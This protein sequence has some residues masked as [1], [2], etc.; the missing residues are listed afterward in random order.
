MAMLM[1]DQW[2]EGHV[3]SLIV[4]MRKCKDM[5]GK[6]LAFAVAGQVHS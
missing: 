1:T 3:A 6:S 4:C 5:H 2:A